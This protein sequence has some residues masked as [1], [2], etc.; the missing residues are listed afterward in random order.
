M[1]SIQDLVREQEGAVALLNS[2][3]ANIMTMLQRGKELTKDVENSPDFIQDL[4]SDLESKWE[5]TYSE[6]VQNLNELKGLRV[7]SL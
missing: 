6:T 4:V 3:R 7:K 1:E 5:D 2:Q